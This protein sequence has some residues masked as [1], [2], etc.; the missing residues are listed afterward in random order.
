MPI[1]SAITDLSTT[2]ASNSPAGSETPIEGDNHLRTAYAFIKQVYD[3]ITASGNAQLASLQNTSVVGNGDALIGELRTATGAVATTA[4]EHNEKRK[5]DVA[6][7]FGV[8]ALSTKIAVKAALQLAISAAGALTA[9]GVIEV[10]AYLNYGYDVTDRTTW[11]D[12]T[13]IT[14]PVTVIDYSQGDSYGIYPTTYDGCQERVWMFTPQTTT[15]DLHDGDTKWLR[16]A[17]QPNVCISNDR[18][19]SGARIATDNRRASFTLFNEGMATWRVGQGTLNSATATSEELSNFTI[20][21]Y[22]APGDTLGA[23]FPV[24]IERKTLNWG[25]NV[26]TNTPQFGIHYKSAV[27]GFQQMCLES[28][29]TTSDLVMRN[30]NGSGDD[31]Y[32][33]NSSGNGSIRIASQG[34]AI[35]FDK[36]NRRVAVTQSFVRKRVSVVYSAS[37]TV[38]AALGNFFTIVAANNTPFTIAITNPAD[39]MQITVRISNTSG[40]ALGG[41]TWTAVKLAGSSWTQPATG[42]N[43]SIILEYDGASWNEVSRSSADVPN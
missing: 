30:S 41:A 16:S 34:D 7:D 2:P 14:V 11:P 15:P 42:S 39:G 8:D 23:S 37:M 12:F 13:G 25:I 9:G 4:H 1:P 27:S 21:K 36:S 6:I 5:F 31:I 3:G 33:R 38:D 28:L 26:G 24:V 22:A 35:T 18:D 43:R 29:T 32:F 40:V 20:E 19:L 17:K 10:P